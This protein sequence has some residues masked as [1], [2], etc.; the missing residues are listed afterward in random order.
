MIEM[1]ITTLV[2]IILSTAMFTLAIFSL[3]VSNRR[4]EDEN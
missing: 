3:L 1:H 2:V 4:D